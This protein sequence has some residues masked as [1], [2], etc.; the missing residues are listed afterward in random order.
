M[1]VGTTTANVQRHDVMEAELKVLQSMIIRIL[2]KFNQQL[3][4]SCVTWS[5]FRTT[6]FL[7]PARSFAPRQ[8]PLSPPPLTHCVS[9]PCPRFLRALPTLRLQVLWSRAPSR[10]R[11]HCGERR[12]HAGRLA[13]GLADASAP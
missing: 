3:L 4:T 7:P 1:T 2:Q 11:T 13:L 5:L 6:P 10:R 12:R 9:A 8:A